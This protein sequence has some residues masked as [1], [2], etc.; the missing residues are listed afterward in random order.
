MKSHRIV[1]LSFL[2]AGVAVT[3]SAQ[4]PQSRVLTLSVA[5]EIAQESMAKCKADG[6][7]VTVLV[8]DALNAPKVM[9]RDDAMKGTPVRVAYLWIQVEAPGTTPV[10][11]PGSTYYLG[12]QNTNMASVFYAV[13]VNFHLVIPTNP[14]PPVI[15]IA[16]IVYTNIGSPNGFLLTWFAPSNYLFQVQWSDSLAPV[17]WQTFTN[18]LPVTYNTNAFTS[19]TNTQF[20]FFDNG[21]QAPFTGTRFYRLLLIT[22]APNTA[23]V[24]NLGSTAT[25]YV[26]PTYGLVVTN[27]ATDAEAPPQARD[28][29]LAQVG[30]AGFSSKYPWQLSGGMQQRASICRAL[31]HEPK[32]L[33]LDEPFSGIDPIAVYEVQKIIRRLRERGLGILITDHNVRETLKLV[34]RAY[35]IHKGEVVYD[36][37]AEQLV[38]DPKAREIYLG[39]EFN[40]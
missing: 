22:N 12:V 14:P 6:Y 3:A 26:T 31:V 8:V 35:L 32:M 19:P 16:S 11:V 5:Q 27:T 28:A 39:P 29:L 1:S 17:N 33:L 18:P 24:F 4:L 15:T 30:L 13:S 20:N 40:M 25:R 2:M 38:N 34:D 7:K 21:S 10:L 23:P 37:V 9:L 36:G